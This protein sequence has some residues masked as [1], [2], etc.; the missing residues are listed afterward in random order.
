MVA[1]PFSRGSS[2]P[3]DPTQVSCIAGRFFTVW[4]TGETQE[5]LYRTPKAWA[6]KEKDKLDLIKIEKFVLQRTPSKKCKDSSQNGRKY[7]NHVT[8][9]GFVSRK[10]MYSYNSIIKRQVTQFKNEQ[11]RASLVAQWLRIRLPVLEKWVQFLI[12]EDPPCCR[13]TKPVYHNYWACAPEPGSCNYWAHVPQLLNPKSP[14]A[15]A[16]QQEKPSLQWEACTSQLV[17]SP[18]SP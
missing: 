17:I 15:C 1:I 7:L 8:D 6:I 11:R 12:Q 2:Q 10:T 13:A 16:V 5:L 4:A 3:R 14:R 18:Y 9:E